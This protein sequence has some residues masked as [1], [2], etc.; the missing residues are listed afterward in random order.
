[1]RVLSMMA[2]RQHTSAS[3]VT[4]ASVGSCIESS[5]PPWTPSSR[6]QRKSSSVAVYFRIDRDPGVDIHKNGVI[7]GDRK[8]LGDPR[9]SFVGHPDATQFGTSS[10]RRVFQ[11]PQLQELRKERRRAQSGANRSPVPISLLTGKGTGKILDFDFEF[12]PR[13]LQSP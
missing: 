4:M 6:C 9:K 13:I 8:C 2:K 11:Q 7:L 10:S 1:M 5:R 12:Q 3:I